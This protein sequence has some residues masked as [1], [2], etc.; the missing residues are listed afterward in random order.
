[1][2]Y[3]DLQPSTVRSRWTKTLLAGALVLGAMAPQAG[4]AQAKPDVAGLHN[5]GADFVLKG[6]EVPN[7]LVTLHT[8]NFLL[9]ALAEGH[10]V[11]SGYV[12]DPLGIEADSQTE[13]KLETF[14]LEA[15]DTVKS[16]LH[17]RYDSDQEPARFRR[18]QLEFRFE[19]MGRMAV[20]H[21]QMLEML[22]RSEAGSQRLLDFMEFE[23]RPTIEVSASGSLAKSAAE[24]R[25]EELS[26]FGYFDDALTYAKRGA[27]LPK[28]AVAFQKSGSSGDMMSLAGSATFP[29]CGEGLLS[30]R[31]WHNLVLVMK[32]RA[33]TLSLRG[34]LKECGFIFDDFV[35]TSCTQLVTATGSGQSISCYSSAGDE[36]CQF[37]QKHRA[38]QR[39]EVRRNG[40]GPL[41]ST[42][43]SACVKPN[44]CD[45]F[46][47]PR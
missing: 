44:R 5:T 41:V 6:E 18:D 23:I 35:G 3:A 37:L 17:L 33:Q 31:G 19:K 13:A 26:I 15:R 45:D 16:T 12:L 25:E 43:Q 14:L 21:S 39:G 2:Q 10:G 8:Y 42:D 22:E 36:V 30:R 32:D 38:W 24:G 40:M 29:N 11:W 9:S 27:E 47:P 20:I 34:Q 4:F 28:P 7:Y 46:L 1:M